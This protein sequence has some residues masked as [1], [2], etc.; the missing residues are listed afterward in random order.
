MDVKQHNN[1]NTTIA[2]KW[3]RTTFFVISQCVQPMLNARN[4]YYLLYSALTEQVHPEYRRSKCKIVLKRYF[5]LIFLPTV[6]YKVF[7]LVTR[8][9]EKDYPLHEKCW[10]LTSSDIPSAFSSSSPVS[11]PSENIRSGL[12]PSNSRSNQF[13][14]FSEKSKISDS[15]S[16][17]LERKI[18]T[19]TAKYLIYMRWIKISRFNQ[20]ERKC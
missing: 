1:N 19:Y 17:Q 12:N 8:S 3:C 10:P 20:N 15:S 4:S 5:L 11:S 2:S 6:L 16:E 13:V 14:T 7:G 18:N 9:R